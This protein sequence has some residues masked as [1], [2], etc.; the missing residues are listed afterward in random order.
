MPSSGLRDFGLETAKEISEYFHCPESRV[1]AGL[2]L[3]VVGTNCRSL[4][5]QEYRA[6]FVRNLGPKH[7]RILSELGDQKQQLIQVA[8]LIAEG[9]NIS[10]IESAL[11]GGSEA[12]KN[13]EEP[14]VTIRLQGK[15]YFRPCIACSKSVMKLLSENGVETSNMNQESE[16]TL[17]L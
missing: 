9:A 5:Q 1:R 14:N 16:P 7:C 6:S 4:L 11:W 12:K 2:E 10:E 3:A 8:R 15:F 17:L 13:E